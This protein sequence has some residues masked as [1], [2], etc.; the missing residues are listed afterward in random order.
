MKLVGFLL[1]LIT[2]TMALAYV[3]SGIGIG[4]ITGFLAFGLALITSLWGFFWQP[5]QK[6]RQQ[7][8]KAQE[9]APEETND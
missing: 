8:K 1:M 9:D 2:P 3:G 5:I 7:N 4:A 6:R